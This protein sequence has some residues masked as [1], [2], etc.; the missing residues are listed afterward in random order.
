MIILKRNLMACF[1]G[2]AILSIFNLNYSFAE[3]VYSHSDS[4]VNSSFYTGQT[5]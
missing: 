5:Y 4:M 3:D 1:M 2:F